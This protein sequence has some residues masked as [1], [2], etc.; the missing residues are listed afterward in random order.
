MNNLTCDCKSDFCKLTGGS[1]LFFNEDLEIM[2]PNVVE[3]ENW[4]WIQ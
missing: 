3:S 2:V 1:D 4:V